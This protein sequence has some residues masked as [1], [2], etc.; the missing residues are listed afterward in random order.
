MKTLRK[1]SGIHNPGVYRALSQTPVSDCKSHTIE[2]KD[3]FSLEKCDVCRGPFS[4]MKWHGV[5]C[6]ACSKTWHMRCFNKLMTYDDSAS[7]EDADMSSGEE[8]VPCSA[9]DTSDDELESPL[10]S[11]HNEDFLTLCGIPATS[12]PVH[13]E[14]VMEDT[15][16][17][18]QCGDS[19]P[20]LEN[21]IEAV[22]TNTSTEEAGRN[23]CFVCGEAQTKLPRHFSKHVKEDADIAKAIS[24]PAKSKE[25]LYLLEHLR[26]RGNFKHNAEVLK[27]GRGL[28]KV[29]RRATKTKVENYE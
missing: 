21:S 27:K 28:L 15:S 6:T 13:A 2:K 22:Q 19:S 7:T 12:S 9:S 4:A 17:Q 3:I 23:Y 29:R 25:R 11:P 24:L 5:I 8:F 14:F 18:Q 26:N 10:T 20:T 16:V 1:Q